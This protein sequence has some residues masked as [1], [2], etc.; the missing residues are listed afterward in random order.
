MNADAAALARADVEAHIVGGAGGRQPGDR[1]QQEQRR[2]QAGMAHDV[3]GRHG[4][5]NW[6]PKWTP[7][8]PPE[9][10]SGRGGSGSLSWMARTAERSKNS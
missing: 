6:K 7:R 1:R 3:G 4:A 9:Y 5:R 10:P 8:S 2:A